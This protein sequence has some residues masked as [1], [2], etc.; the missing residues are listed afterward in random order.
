MINKPVAL[1]YNCCENLVRAAIITRPEEDD[2]A[3]YYVYD[4]AEQRTGK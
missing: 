2:D 4:S 1:D 3:D